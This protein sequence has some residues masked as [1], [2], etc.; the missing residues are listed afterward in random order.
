ME[1]AFYTGKYRNFFEEQG[2]NS[3]EITSRLEKIF[4]T[5]FYGPDD[6][7]FYHESGSDMGYWRTQEIMMC[8]RKECLWHDGLCSDE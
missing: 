4:Q 7:R 8:V 5:I 3:E 1:G 2:Y 6:E